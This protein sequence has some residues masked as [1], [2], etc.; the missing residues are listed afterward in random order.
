MGTM[1][2][3]LLQRMPLLF[4]AVQFYCI[5]TK[6]GKYIEKEQ[7]PTTTLCYNNIILQHSSNEQ[8]C[9]AA[10]MCKAVFVLACS[11][12]IYKLFITTYCWH[13]MYT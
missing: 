11:N 12:F 3:F 4:V 9:D 13:I 1:Q 6:A 7:M 10:H 2:I 5:Y 8:C